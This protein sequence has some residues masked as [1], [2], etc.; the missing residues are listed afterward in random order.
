MNGQQQQPSTTSFI[1]SNHD[2]SDRQRASSEGVPKSAS[3]AA[4]K[5]RR[6]TSSNLP[7]T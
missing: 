5:G 1:G 6:R 2:P 3:E 4:N 7:S